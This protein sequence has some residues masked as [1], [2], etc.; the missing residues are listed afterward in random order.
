MV[1]LL[2]VDNT[3]MFGQPPNV[4]YNDNLI[5]TLLENGVKDIYLFSSMSLRQ[6]TVEERKALTKY[7]ESKGLTVH[8]TICA[9]DLL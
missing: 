2:D 1:A 6:H 8:G 7:L 5:D 9:A 3:L 4:E